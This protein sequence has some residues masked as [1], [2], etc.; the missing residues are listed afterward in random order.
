MRLTQFSVRGFHSY[1]TEQSVRFEPDLTILAGRNNV[2][3]T[4]LLRALRLPQES[5]P[6]AAPDKALSYTWQLSADEIRAAVNLDAIESF[7]SIV[8]EIE[9]RQGCELHLLLHT[10]LRPDDSFP[11]AKDTGGGGPRTIGEFKIDR[12]E[13]VGTDIRLGVFGR[14]E[15]NPH[16][17]TLWWES[18]QIRGQPSISTSL[19]QIGALHT[20]ATNLIRAPYYIR[21]RRTTSRMAFQP[22]RAVTADGGNLTNVLM[23]LFVNDRHTLFQKIETFICEVFPDIKSVEV[24]TVNDGAPPEIEIYMAFRRRGGLEVPLE[25]CGTGIEQLLMLATAVV[26]APQPGIFLVDEPHAFLH[27]AAER[28]LLRFLQQHSEHQYVV[29]THSPTFLNAYPLAHTRLISIDENGS[30]ITSVTDKAE[31]LEAVG[32]TAADLWTA[33]AILWLEGP[34]DI[35]VIARLLKQERIGNPIILKAMPD[36]VRASGA[37]KSKAAQAMEFYE[38]VTSAILPLKVDVL[39][40]FDSDEKSAERKEEI[41]EAT[42]HRARFLPVRELENLFL[43]AQAIAEDVRAICVEYERPTPTLEQIQGQIQGLVVATED[44]ELYPSAGTPAG[45]ERIVGSAVLRRLY[46]Q[47]AQYDYDK[48]IDGPRLADHVQQLEPAFLEPL[49]AL[50]ESFHRTQ[51]VVVQ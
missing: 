23:T 1:D 50:I 45:I 20:L 33:D 6:G 35:A 46:R 31:I 24:H 3:K 27:P 22:V 5:T 26:T 48:V 43:S 39:F 14:E 10:P 51:S 18:E 44:R 28:G 32:V 13:L 4:S 15:T 16:A 49:M 17:P 47:W 2:G 7:R 41:E 34:S 25:Y 30:H 40:I 11:L 9:E 37:S 29:A 21:P 12:L 8:S 38:A 42:G 19:T 36:A